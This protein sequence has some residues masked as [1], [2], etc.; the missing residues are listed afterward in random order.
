MSLV[1]VS[2][3]KCNSGNAN[4]EPF[5]RNLIILQFLIDLAHQII[6]LTLQST[7]GLSC[8]QLTILNDLEDVTIGFDAGNFD[9]V[10]IHG[11]QLVCGVRFPPPVDTN[12]GYMGVQVKGF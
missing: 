7:I 9:A 2:V 4:G 11:S 10:T 3:E 5:V 6:H 1:L 12:I 8:F